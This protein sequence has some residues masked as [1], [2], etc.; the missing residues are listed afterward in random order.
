MRRTAKFAPLAARGR[1]VIGAI[2]AT[3]ALFSVLSVV[4]RKSVV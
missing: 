3:F 1:R 2:L 4:D